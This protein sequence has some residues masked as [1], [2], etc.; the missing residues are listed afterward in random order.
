NDCHHRRRALDDLA[1]APND[2]G[3]LVHHPYSRRDCGGH[4]DE[5]RGRASDLCNSE[6]LH[7]GRVFVGAAAL[8]T[9]AGGGVDGR[10]GRVWK[11]AGRRGGRGFET[12]RA[13]T[14]GG[15]VSEGTA[16]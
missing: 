1:A 14:V 13:A 3:F 16:V 2:R 7:R 12:S 10:S 9:G 5:W 15:P 4:W 11:R 6:P 8:F